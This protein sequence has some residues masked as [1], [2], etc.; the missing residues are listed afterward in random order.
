M[1]SFSVLVISHSTAGDPSFSP[2]R[3]FVTKGE[4]IPMKFKVFKQF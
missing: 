4:D 2:R 3:M 1:Q